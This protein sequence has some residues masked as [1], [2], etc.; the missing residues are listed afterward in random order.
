MKC[1]ILAVKNKNINPD[2][3]SFSV[4]Y[5][6]RCFPEI[7]RLDFNPGEKIYVPTNLFYTFKTADDAA[8]YNAINKKDNIILECECSDAVVERIKI[9]SASGLIEMDMVKGQHFDIIRTAYDFS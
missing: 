4:S 9:E 6:H 3:K 1:Y 7:C 8:R 5:E 2:D